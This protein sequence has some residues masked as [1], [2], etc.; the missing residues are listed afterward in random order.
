[1]MRGD[2]A[3]RTAFPDT[4]RVDLFLAGGLPAGYA[5]LIGDTIRATSQDQVRRFLPPPALMWAAL[6]RLVLPTLPDTTV[7]MQGDTL[8]ATIGR[9]TEWR[10]RVVGGRLTQLV[11]V[12]GGRIAESVTRVQGGR[13]LYEVPGRRRLWLGIVRDEEVPAFDASIWNR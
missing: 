11:R 10:V 8:N 6:G 9:P 7:T 5:I 12:S 1:M 3:I 4:A 2:G 13:L